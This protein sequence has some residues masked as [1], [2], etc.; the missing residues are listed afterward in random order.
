MEKKKK[1]G[2]VRITI[3]TLSLKLLCQGFHCTATNGGTQISDS[4]QITRER[5]RERERERGILCH[6]CQLDQ[7]QQTQSNPV[8]DVLDH[9][10]SNFSSTFFAL[11][12][13]SY[14][15]DSPCD[16]SSSTVL[17]H[18]NTGRGFIIPK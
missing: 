7:L 18:T 9:S 11:L 16:S 5:E 6:I 13:L 17:T 12:F 4:K 15:Y 1:N 10:F 8:Q 3:R 2:N 14:D